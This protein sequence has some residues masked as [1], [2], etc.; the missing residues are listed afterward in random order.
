M[1]TEPFKKWEEMYSKRERFDV[2]KPAPYDPE[3]TY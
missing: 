2:T 1:L 3:E